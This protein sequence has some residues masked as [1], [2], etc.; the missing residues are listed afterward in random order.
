M[1][2][3]K[4]AS[5]A[6]PTD[7]GGD[8]ATKNQEIS[9]DEGDYNCKDSGT[10]VDVD[11]FKAIGVYQLLHPV[12]CGLD[13]GLCRMAVKIIVGLT[14]GLQ[15]IQVCRLYL[16]R[17]DIPMF[18]N[19]GVLVVYGLMCLFKG[20]TL[21]THAD[22]ICTTLEVAR[23]SFTSCGGRYPS[24]MRQCRARLST[25][26]RTFVGLSFGTLFVWLI[27]PWFLTSEYDDK[28]IV[29][30][31]VYVVESI[32]F[33]VN[34][35]CWTSFDCYLV[36]MCFVFEAVFRTMSYGYENV[37]RVHRLYPHAVQPFLDYR[38]K[39]S[40]IQSDVPLKFPDHYDDLINHIK[41]NQ[42]IVEKY[43]TFFDVVQ[44]VVLLQI[45][46][47]SY[48]VITLIFLISISYLNGDSII[49]PAILKFFCGLASV[50]IEL[51]IFCYGFNHI[52]V[53]RST[54][55]F[56]LYCCDWTEKDLKFKKTVLLAMSMNSAHKQVMK[57]SPN[58][59]VN[60]EMFARVMNMSYTI[61]ST[62]LS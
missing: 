26:L 36:T 52:E 6:A 38:S 28:P 8:E 5:S 56:G 40:D 43:E 3:S 10:I 54:V 35:F 11:L 2:R 27:I 60:L 30:A 20:Y 7:N 58:S 9:S 12:E 44:P 23:Y 53:G 21:A 49:S 14:L 22:R 47:G 29:W 61:V 25:I 55:N 15:S 46:D 51:F 34:V 16:A 50:I 24:L 41:D 4:I 33:T 45:A 48:S 37:G 39:D 18:A 57:L 42:K 1:R 32:I 13:S 31:V 17:Y 62:L 19:M 59:I